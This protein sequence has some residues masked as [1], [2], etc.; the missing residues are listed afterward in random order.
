MVFRT[1]TSS[2]FKY[3]IISKIKLKRIKRYYI[4]NIN[5]EQSTDSKSVKPR[6]KKI[7]EKKLDDNYS[8]A[9][10]TNVI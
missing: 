8:E 1:W 5:M 10:L 2:P 7:Y 9:L 4:Y 3:R 6:N